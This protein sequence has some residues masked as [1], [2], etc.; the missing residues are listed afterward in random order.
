[1]PLLAGLLISFCFPT[2]PDHPLA[3]VHGSAWAFIALVPLF[4]SLAS[5]TVAECFRRGWIAGA[6]FSLYSL[7]WVASTQGGGPAV[8]AGTFLM[9]AYLG[10]FY[11]LFAAILRSALLAW[12]RTGWLLAPLFWTLI[13]YLLSIGELAFPWLLLGNTQA[14]TVELIQYAELTGV[15]GVSFWVVLV[16]AVIWLTVQTPIRARLAPA[17]A[18]LVMLFACPWWYAS[19]AMKGAE[20]PGRTI[21]VGL[22]QNNLGRQKW[23]AGG[24]ERSFDGL[25]SLS[26]AA[27]A[28]GPQLLVWP[29]TAVPCRLQ[30]RDDCRGRVVALV[31]ELQ[32][33]VLTGASHL[34][35]RT[36]DP[37]NAAFYFDGGEE[38]AW[39]AK[40]HLV[41]FG[42]RTPFV[43][44]I[45]LFADIDWTALTGDLG[46]AEFARG[47][48]RTLFAHPDG[49]FAV[50]ICFESVFPDF[51]RRSV[52]AGALFLVNITNDSWFGRTAGPYQHAQLAV[53]RA[54]ENRTAIARCATS[55]VSLFI[56]PFGRT[57]QETDLFVEAYRV[58]DVAIASQQTFY[59]RHGDLFAQTTAA[60]AVVLTVV[61]VVQRRRR[62]RG[63]QP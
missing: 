25:E 51:V 42:E 10:L 44:A 18:C 48:V 3:W 19:M 14:A 59:T 52:A 38:L 61:S 43:D 57:S 29:E 30:F 62:D 41:P 22:V 36:R 55:G 15:F 47:T 37:Y 20:D 2:H 53:L 33:P 6:A 24:L 34:D 9:A 23:R 54:V 17:A 26:R 16:N 58:G 21:R 49:A 4:H 5:A 28:A 8:V 1:M 46:P 11:G 7:Y 39:Y 50:L 63:R 40:M 13:E 56:D 27:A 12:P 31:D 32:I 45:P 60:L 35:R